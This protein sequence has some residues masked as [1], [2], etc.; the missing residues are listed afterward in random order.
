M[1]YAASFTAMRAESKG[2]QT[3][4]L[5]D[6]IDKCQV[7]VHVV[8]VVAKKDFYVTAICCVT[9]RGHP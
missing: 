9:V 7:Y 4:V 5:S 1:V 6:F 2:I 8:K 3:S